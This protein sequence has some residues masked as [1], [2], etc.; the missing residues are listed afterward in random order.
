VGPGD[1]NLVNHEWCSSKA[2]INGTVAHT[3]AIF[4]FMLAGLVI[5]DIL[6]E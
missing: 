2:Q 5:Q 4:G 3:T 6:G 1:P